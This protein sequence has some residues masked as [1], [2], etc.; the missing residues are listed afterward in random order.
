M[1]NSNMFHLQ[2]DSSYKDLPTPR[3]DHKKVCYQIL[4]Q[5]DSKLCKL[6]I[7]VLLDR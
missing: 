2:K 3:Y 4:I 1:E 6:D 5:T 7:M